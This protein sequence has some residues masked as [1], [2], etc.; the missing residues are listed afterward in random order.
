MRMEF[1]ASEIDDPRKPRR[2]IDNNFF[3]GAARRERERYGAQPQG[4]LRWRALL[5]ERF[6]FGAIDV[7]FEDKWTVS[8]SGERARCDRQIVTNQ[9]EF[10]E[11]GLP[12]K[13][14]LVRVSDTDL[15][16][17]NRKQLGR[18][19]VPHKLSLHDWR[20]VAGFIQTLATHESEAQ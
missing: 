4:V 12:G 2:I 1:D 18:I 14:Q 6:T 11:L 3:R 15:A 8:D 17:V 7:P 10:R 5:I 20:D 19:F 16:S 9:V 13:V